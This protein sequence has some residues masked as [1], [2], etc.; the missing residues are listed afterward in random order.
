MEV[1]K[2][3]VTIANITRNISEKSVGP[4]EENQTYIST[5]ITVTPKIL[6]SP[7]IEEILNSPLIEEILNSPPIELILNFIG[8]ILISKVVGGIL[9][10]I[11]AIRKIILPGIV[12]LYRWVKK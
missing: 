10:I 1:N 12:K 6:N 4:I 7:L 8:D 11:L 9:A 3:E 5:N 2:T